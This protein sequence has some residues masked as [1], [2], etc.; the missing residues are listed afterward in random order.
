MGSG[1]TRK[2]FN[3]VVTGAEM[4]ITLQQIQAL[5]LKERR[6]LGGRINFFLSKEYFVSKM[7]KKT[8]TAIQEQENEN[9]RDTSN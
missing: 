4:N 5:P 8:M 1:L 6:Q 3:S 9:V 2:Y 7:R